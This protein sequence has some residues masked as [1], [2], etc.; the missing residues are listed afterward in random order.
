MSLM[1]RYARF[2][3]RLRRRSATRSGKARGRTDLL[4]PNIR[5]I[6]NM[7][8]AHRKDGAIC[9]VRQKTGTE[10]GIPNMRA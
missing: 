2:K 1:A 4:G 10:V 8:R 9:V 3:R 6:A 7:T 5:H